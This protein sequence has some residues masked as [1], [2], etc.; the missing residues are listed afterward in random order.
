MLDTRATNKALRDNLKALPEYCVQVKGDIDKV[1]SYFMQ[2]L[3]QL[4]ARGEGADDKE[5]IWFTAYQ[6]V[7]DAEFGK[8][9]SKKK[10]NYY[11]NI[12]DRVNADYKVIMLKAKTKYDMLI[13]SKD[14]PFGTPSDEEQQVLALK[15]E[16]E[17]FKDSNF[18]LSKQLRSKIK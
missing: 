7:P 3:N 17:Q 2:N 18:K 1:N 4:L 11:N 16:L 6:H 13:S 12:N 15:A 9:I 14:R 10:D 5:D 8:Y